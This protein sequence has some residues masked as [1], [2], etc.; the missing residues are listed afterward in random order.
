MSTRLQFLL[1]IAAIWFVIPGSATLSTPRLEREL[2]EQMNV[3]AGRYVTE[4]VSCV[5]SGASPASTYA[6]ALRG[7]DGASAGIRVEVDGDR[8]R[9]YWAPVSG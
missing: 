7:V 1:G 8:W 3:G 2:Q 4:D 6:C 9:A 5:R